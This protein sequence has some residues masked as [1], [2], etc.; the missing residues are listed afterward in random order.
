M[1]GARAHHRSVPSRPLP[2]HERRNPR[3]HRLGFRDGSVGEYLRTERAVLVSVRPGLDVA[4]RAGGE[5]GFDAG[6]PGELPLAEGVAFVRR[7]E[8]ELSSLLSGVILVPLPAVAGGTGASIRSLG[9]RFG[10]HA[11]DRGGDPHEGPADDRSSSYQIAPAYPEF[12]VHVDPLPGLVL[13]VHQAH[14]HRVAR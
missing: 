12:A 10:R 14:L 2:W 6:A 3:R 8:P 13:L 11:L 9:E 7:G 1:S 4:V 5:L